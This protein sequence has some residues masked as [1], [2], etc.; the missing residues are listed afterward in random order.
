M[1]RDL[2]VLG[3]AAGWIR[4]DLGA[5]ILVFMNLLRCQELGNRCLSMWVRPTHAERSQAIRCKRIAGCTTIALQ[6]NRTPGE[7]YKGNPTASVDRLALV[8]QVRVWV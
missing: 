7:S 5:K 3:R 1:E 4:D 6:V 8:E 2:V